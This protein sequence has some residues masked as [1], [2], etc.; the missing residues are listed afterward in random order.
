MD[1]K[2]IAKHFYEVIVSENRLDEVLQYVSKNCV[3]NMNGKIIPIGFEGIKEHMIAVR[4]TYPAYTMQIT[5]QFVDG[6]YV[7]SEFI[8]TGTHEGEW[9]GMKPTHKKLS[10][11]GV[12]I[13]KIFGEKIVE[14]SGAVN[15][16]EMLW[17]NGLI[18]AIEYL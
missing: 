4:K 14:H 8:M 9:L 6:D 12:N 2:S 16:F 3:L 15:T 10:F 18:K 13:D 17:E 11:S 5:R 1:N 7:I